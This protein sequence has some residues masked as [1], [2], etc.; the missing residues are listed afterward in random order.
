MLI[1]LHCGMHN[2]TDNRACC[3]FFYFLGSL[4]YD[5]AMV[6][7]DRSLPLG[8]Y[9]LMLKV[10][11]PPS[12]VYFLGRPSA[13]QRCYLMGWGCIK[14]GGRP[15]SHGRYARF[16]VMKN[17]DCSRIYHH[18]AGLNANHEFCAGY[19]NQSIGI[20]PVSF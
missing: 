12:Q 20:C 18:A 3:D 15:A 4:E 16:D 14:A 13:G 19:Y 10:K 8:D 7:M 9:P 17:S 6:K 11:L 5:I 1:D 2:W